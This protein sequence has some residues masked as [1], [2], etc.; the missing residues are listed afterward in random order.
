M[1][2]YVYIEIKKQQKKMWQHKQK[3]QY[4]QTIQINKDQQQQPWGYTKLLN[5]VD[6]LFYVSTL[7]R[8]STI[9]QQIARI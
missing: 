5:T 8:D 6:S 9:L 4:L 1:G 3:S 2:T 7:F